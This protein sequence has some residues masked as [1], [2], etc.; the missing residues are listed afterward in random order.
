MPSRDV[1]S[2]GCRKKTGTAHD[3]AEPVRPDNPEELTSETTKLP[4][5]STTKRLSF[6]VD[7]FT[8]SGQSRKSLVGGLG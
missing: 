1:V 4:V 3:P 7:R 5:V 8:G 6:K 2:A